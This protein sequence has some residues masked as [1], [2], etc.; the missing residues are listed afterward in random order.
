MLNDNAQTFF[1]SSYE[2]LR[3]VSCK[4]RRAGGI[5]DLEHD[6][7]VGSFDRL[8]FL[9]PSIGDDVNPATLVV[10]SSVYPEFKRVYHSTSPYPALYSPTKRCLIGMLTISS[11]TCDAM[12]VFPCS[13]GRVSTTVSDLCG[14]WRMSG[15]GWGLVAVALEGSSVPGP[16]R[17]VGPLYFM[18]VRWSG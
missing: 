10:D 2:F 18:P 4:K 5:F 6:G 3:L 14:L 9:S 8:T 13:F 11:A 12:A 7:P 16:R 1:K 17:L 15:G